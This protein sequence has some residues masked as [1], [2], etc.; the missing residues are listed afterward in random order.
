MRFLSLVCY[1]MHVYVPIYVFSRVRG[2]VIGYPWQ[3]VYCIIAR[4][5][6]SLFMRGKKPS[7]TTSNINQPCICLLWNVLKFFI[8]WFERNNWWNGEKVNGLLVH[9]KIVKWY[10]LDNFVDVI[11]RSMPLDYLPFTS[12]S[13]EWCEFDTIFL[14]NLIWMSDLI[15]GFVFV[16]IHFN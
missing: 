1:T 14:F 12:L 4:A 16:C 3:Y 9:L 8:L 13:T 5:A 15:G 2:V 6:S 11:Y 10:T 7:M